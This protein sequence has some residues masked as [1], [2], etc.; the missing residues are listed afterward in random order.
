MSK[1][2]KRKVSAEQV[3]GEVKAE[4][5]EMKKAKKEGRKA[6]L[7]PPPAP[8]IELDGIPNPL[9]GNK[10]MKRALAVAI[11]LQCKKEDG[12]VDESKAGLLIRASGICF[13]A[14]YTKDAPTDT[15][16]QSEWSGRPYANW[17]TNNPQGQAYPSKFPEKLEKC[18]PFA[19]VLVG[20][21]TPPAVAEPVQ[22]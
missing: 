16:T 3:A 15:L 12:K 9:I 18:V 13:K 1:E 11:V 4:G 20:V 2:H 14:G 5:T 6:Q 10:N 22:A 8:P 17:A 21:A 19:K 7:A